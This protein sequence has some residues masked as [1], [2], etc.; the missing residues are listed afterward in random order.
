MDRRFWDKRKSK[1]ISFR[2]Y[3]EQYFFKNW[4]TVR[5]CTSVQDPDPHPDPDP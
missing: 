5:E 1:N 2:H 4:T 3:F